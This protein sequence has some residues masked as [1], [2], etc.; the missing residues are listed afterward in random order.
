MSRQAQIAPILF[1]ATSLSLRPSIED[2]HWKKP[3]VVARHLGEESP[4]R[5][6]KRSAAL[7]ADDEAATRNLLQW[8]LLGACL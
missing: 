1:K 2:T 3:A 8:Y 6:G 7:L 5:S 4:V